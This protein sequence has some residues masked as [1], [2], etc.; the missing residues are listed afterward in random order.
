MGT[1]EFDNIDDLWEQYF[2]TGDAEI[3]NKII[4]HYLYIVGIVVKRLMPQYK[5]YSEKDELMSCGVL[6]LI[7]A[8]NKSTGR[9]VKFQT[10]ATSEPRRI[11]DSCGSRI[12][13]RQASG[14]NQQH[15]A[16]L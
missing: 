4:S 11:I 5:D 3:K 16:G 8:V 2:N 10:Y 13:R 1:D 14:K 9:S 7:D 12:G 15:P 6:G